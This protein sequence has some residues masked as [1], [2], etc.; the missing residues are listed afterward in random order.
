[1]EVKRPEG[2]K[3]GDK[4]R[5]KISGFT[6]VVVAMTEW[7]NGCLRITIQP[8]ELKDGKPIENHTFDAEQIEIV[9]PIPPIVAKPHGG[10]SISPTRAS[11]P[12]R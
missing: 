7:L 9:E 4:A 12:S 1:M 6:G 2:L 10:P 11:D 5:D 8:Q 3:L